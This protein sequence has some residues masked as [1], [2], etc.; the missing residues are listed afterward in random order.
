M[1][2]FRWVLQLQEEEQQKVLKEK[3]AKG[4]EEGHL[5]VAPGAGVG[6]IHSIDSA[7]EVVKSVWDAAC[8][9]M[10]ELSRHYNSR[11]MDLLGYVPFTIRYPDS[12]FV[13]G[14]MQQPKAAT[15]PP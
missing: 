14:P 11:G 4:Q 3:L 8:V 12:P 2:A 10:F 9:R 1:Q 7:E 5:D 13:C 6:Q 15:V